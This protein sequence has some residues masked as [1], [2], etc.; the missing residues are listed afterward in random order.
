MSERV[1]PVRTL[2]PLQLD[3]TT[4]EEFDAWTGDEL[5]HEVGHEHLAP[6]CLA[7]N[8]RR[9]VHGGTEEMIS[10]VQRVAGVN[11]DPDADRR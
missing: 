6:E 10:L 2:E 11:A 9:V 8:T 4:L 3:I 7:R 5:A 1:Q